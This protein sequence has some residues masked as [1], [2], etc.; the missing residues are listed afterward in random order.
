M[1]LDYVV[2]LV[3]GRDEELRQ[4]V[5]AGMIVRIPGTEEYHVGRYGLLGGRALG[6]HVGDNDIQNSV[7][8]GFLEDKHLVVQT[9]RPVELLLFFLELVHRLPRVSPRFSLRV[10]YG[11]TE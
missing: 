1:P 8:F 5:G 11:V 7:Q 6:C 3:H 2:D 4:E 9:S 10:V